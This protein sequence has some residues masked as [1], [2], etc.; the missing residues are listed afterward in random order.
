V[1]NMGLQYTDLPIWEGVLNILN[2]YML[3]ACYLPSPSSATAT[4]Q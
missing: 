2:G 4:F 1:G 3:L